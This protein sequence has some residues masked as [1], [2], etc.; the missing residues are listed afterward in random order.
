MPR[1]RTS[2][3]AMSTFVGI[4]HVRFSACH[5]SRQPVWLECSTSRT[6]WPDTSLRPTASSSSNFSEAAI[7]LENIRLYEDLQ[8]REA[9]IRRLVDSNIIG[10]FI[11]YANGRLI[12]PNTR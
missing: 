6:T 10:L 8:D 2:F 12:D 7:S 11:G 3:P 9:K 1:A 4:T 5:C